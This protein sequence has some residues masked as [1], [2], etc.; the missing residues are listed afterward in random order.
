MGFFDDVKEFFG[1][2]KPEKAQAGMGKAAKKAAAPHDID[3]QRAKQDR[4]MAAQQFD[5][6]EARLAEAKKASLSKQNASYDGQL[7]S[8]RQRYNAAYQKIQ[9]ASAAGDASKGEATQAEYK[10]AKAA[11]D[12]IQDKNAW[13]A[14]NP[15]DKFVNPV[16]KQDVA[17]ARATLTRCEKAY[18]EALNSAMSR[19]G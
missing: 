18:N 16:F 12:A 11:Y 6:A 19:A 5:K 3:V 4:D 17:D 13:F 1:G 9:S 8:A 10:Q 14:Q 15:P 7:A 2:G